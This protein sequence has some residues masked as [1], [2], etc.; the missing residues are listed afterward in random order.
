MTNNQNSQLSVTYLG[1]PTIIIE[2]GG[3]RFMT[4]PTL[5]PEGTFF[6]LNEK[7]TE[8]KLS[9]PAAFPDKSIDV[10]LLS[11]DQHFDNLD[12]MGRTFLKEVSE[13]LT[14]KAGAERLKEN[15]IGLDP[16][17]HRFFTTPNGEKIKVTAT[18]ARHG[19]AGI[20]K[21]TG[22]VIGFH[23]E[24]DNPGG[25]QL[26]ITGDTV[27]YNEIERLSKRI[28]PNYVF[29]FAGAARP[30]GPFNVTM[31]TNDAIDTAAAFPKSILIPIHSEGWSHY[32]ENNTNLREAFQ[33]IGI[34]NQLKILEPG[35]QT[36]LPV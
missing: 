11:H 27:Y 25:I 24:V 34:E 4:D 21:I 12:G 7:M 8:R 32:T 19:P 14:T 35:V 18:P 17:E 9:G 6:K 31:S 28:A 36:V 13:V 30:R 2:I 10:V 33:I 22:D 3:L 1:G 5:D 20:E 26:Y 16:N 29:I 15:T 23:V